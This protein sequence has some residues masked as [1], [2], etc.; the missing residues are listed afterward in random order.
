MRNTHDF[1][2][3]GG[4]QVGL[5]KFGGEPRTFGEDNLRSKLGL[6]GLSTWGTRYEIA[7]TA[8]KLSNDLSRTSASA[9]FDPEHEAAVE[10]T[11]TQ[12]LARNYGPEVQLAQVRVRR[13]NQQA[14]EFQFKQKVLGRIGELVKDYYDLLLAFQDFKTRQA[15][16]GTAAEIAAERRE[17]LERGAIAPS[18][19]HLAETEI[20]RA[21]ERFLLA[22]QTLLQVSL[23]L[24]RRMG[25]EGGVEE[26]VL[27]PV[28]GP[29]HQVPALER[30][31]L[32]ARALETSPAYRAAQR[33]VEGLDVEVAFRRD[34]TRPE[35]DL[36]MKYGL[37]GVGN[38]RRDA[39]DA[40]A[41][42]TGT[43]Y[44]VGVSLRMPIGNREA[45]GRLAESRL[46]RRQ[47]E[48]E[49]SR[50]RHEIMS[51]ID[52]ALASVRTHGER[53]DAVRRT[54]GMAERNLSE[55]RD[56]LEKGQVGELAVRRREHELREARLRELTAVVDLEKS[57]A[58]LWKSDGTLL[59]R[60]GVEVE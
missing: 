57:L 46:L 39:F 4:A 28:S 8:D 36:E 15:E 13:A 9:L 10:F 20:A 60:Y 25:A 2:T 21:Y 56:R 1:G 5:A 17:Q 54:V 14:S 16:V 6:S 52:K 22:R 37:N 24:S 48:L 31:D 38:S 51:R 34:Q 19:L 45:R 47:A 32:L 50:L 18:E 58:E 11:V 59:T 23:D 30:G 35:V 29:A 44:S 40:V 26:A 43:E 33:K 3:T 53:V 7:V 12:P 41:A 27:L 55:E 49:A 42:G